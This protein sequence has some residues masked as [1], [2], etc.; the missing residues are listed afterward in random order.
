VRV[1]E[2]RPAVLAELRPG[3]EALGFGKRADWVFTTELGEDV[4]GWLGLNETWDGYHQE[5]SVMAFV[6]VRHQE[7][8]RVCAELL[9]E[10]F[11]PYH[12]VTL[13][14]DLG[15]LLAPRKL[16][17]WRFQAGEECAPEA[18]SLATAVEDVGLPWM[19]G[20]D[21]L[22]RMIDRLQTHGSLVYRD[23]FVLPLALAL[24]GR[25]PEALAELERQ[26]V[27][28][29]GQTYPL[30]RDVHAFADSFRRRFTEGAREP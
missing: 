21:S 13:K 26:L 18:E 10:S 23:E 7:V 20:L 12:P 30:A 16:I 15:T 27:P 2:V 29:R 11:H 25:A 8:E 4:L 19:R 14:E 6:G 9:G 17:L 22:E 3:I 1:S 28:Y 5:L 24:A